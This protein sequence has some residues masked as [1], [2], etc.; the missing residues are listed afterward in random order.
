MLAAHVETNISSMA[1]L[2]LS[3]MYN[4]HPSKEEKLNLLS[5][6]TMKP[7]VGLNE[8]HVTNVGFRIGDGGGNFAEEPSTGEGS[9][10]E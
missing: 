6:K 9:V 2:K 8:W 10:G 3:E 7:L 1:Q 5:S 4:I